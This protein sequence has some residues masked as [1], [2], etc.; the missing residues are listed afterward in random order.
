AA[1]GFGRLL[2]GLLRE[3]LTGACQLDHAGLVVLTSR[4]PFADLGTFDGSSARMLELPAFTP[5]EGAALL[6][7]AGGRWLPEQE[8]RALVAPVAGPALA[9]TVLAGLLAAHWPA[10]DLGALRE[11]LATATRTDTRVSKVLGFYGGRLAESDRY[12]LAAVSLFT[13]PVTAAAVL[14]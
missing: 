13:R 2:D 10:T 3:V 9:V 4:F 12:L 5:T 8:R 11:E 7:T 1:E 14:A 6:A